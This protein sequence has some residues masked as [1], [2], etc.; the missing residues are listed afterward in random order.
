MVSG[1]MVKVLCERALLPLWPHF[2]PQPPSLHIPLVPSATLT[3]MGCQSHSLP[4]PLSECP[5]RQR[6]SQVS[7]PLQTHRYSSLPDL[8]S[9]PK[10]C[11]VSLIVLL[12]VDFGFQLSPVT[13]EVR[14][15]PDHHPP[16][17]EWRGEWRGQ[18]QGGRSMCV[19]HLSLLPTPMSSFSC[20]LVDLG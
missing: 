16:S 9:L 5:P 15:R 18:W 14:A 6:Y 3:Q 1:P 13:P 12:Q 20:F 8:P 19:A 2:S 17:G 11:F 7:L 10:S 4:P